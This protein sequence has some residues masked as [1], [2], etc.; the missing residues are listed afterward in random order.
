[1]VLL[2][3]SLN[4]VAS[5]YASNEGDPVSAAVQIL[6]DLYDTMPAEATIARTCTTGYG[7]GL[8]KAALEAEDGEVETMAHYRAADHLLPG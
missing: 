7:E 8:V 1:S 5:H 2:D 6:A 4:I 3:E